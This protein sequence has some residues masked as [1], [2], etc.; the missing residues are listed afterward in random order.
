MSFDI[1]ILH[2]PNYPHNT[3]KTY[4]LRLLW[5]PSQLGA[6]P[7]LPT[8]ASQYPSA[9]PCESRLLLGKNSKGQKKPSHLKV[10][11]YTEHDPR[12]L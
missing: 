8:P 12:S 3:K 11:F 10:G 1:Y 6:S 9:V 5:L 7:Q 4:Q 2:L